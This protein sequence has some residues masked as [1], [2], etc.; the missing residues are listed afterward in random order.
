MRSRVA[1][2]LSEIGADAPKPDDRSFGADGESAG[3]RDNDFEM[4]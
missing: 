2:G 4:K 1:W 3:D